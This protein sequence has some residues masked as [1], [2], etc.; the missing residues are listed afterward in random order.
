MLSVN[1]MMIKFYNTMTRKKELFKPRKG[2]KVNIFV[3][4]PTVYDFSHIGHARTYVSY[5]TLVKY[6]R[7]QGYNVFYLQNITDIDDK[8]I[9]RA[10]REGVSPKSLAGKFTKEYFKDMESLG[11]D[12]VSKYAKATD[13]IPQIVSQVE[14]LKSKGFAYDIYDGIYFDL[15]KFKSYGKLAGRT[16]LEGE[17]AVSRIDDSVKKK[18]K[19]DF[20]LWKFSK[21]GE[22]V[23]KSKLGDGRPGWHIEDTAITETEFGPQ[24]EIHGGARDLIFPHHEAEIAQMESISGK[25][26]LA[27]YW[28]HTGFL[29]VSG[30]KMAKSLGNFITIR[31]ALK[32]NS[33]EELRFF[34]LSSHYRTPVDYNDSNIKKS[35]V[36]LSRL[37][38]LYNTSSSSDGLK[39][40]NLV[41]KHRQEFYRQLE[42]DFNTPRAIAVLFDLMR[43]VNKLSGYGKSLKE[44]LDEVNTIFGIFIKDKKSKIPKNIRE[45]INKRDTARKRKDWKTA[46]KIRITLREKG[47]L[48]EDNPKGVKVKILK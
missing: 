38:E 2:K 40:K 29:N 27:K 8:I 23:W 15:S 3:C 10:K 33:P 24:Y 21:P 45:L 31:D 32:E 42:D 18:N 28:M 7:A 44:F 12:S 41:T 11:I 47:F 48:I 13:Y 1:F 14:R 5:D 30:R 25:E 16:T 4:G 43:S 9:A 35:K 26:P 34:F 37:N 19:G 22:P 20:A 36:A 39:L 17:D 46:D 6:L